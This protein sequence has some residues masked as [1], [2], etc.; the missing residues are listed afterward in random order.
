[1]KY[2]GEG[3]VCDWCRRVVKGKPMPAG[4]T[5]IR[6]RLEGGPRHNA[7]WLLHACHDCHDR[8]V[9]DWRGL[10]EHV[11]ARNCTICCSGCS[12]GGSD[13]RF[14][15]ECETKGRPL[16]QFELWYCQGCFCHGRA[17]VGCIGWTDGRDSEGAWSTS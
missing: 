4:W 9:G 1:M 5:R 7:R 17:L 3:H 16:L 11:S 13:S 8:S 15:V 2:Y 12:P 10:S 14:I 6:I